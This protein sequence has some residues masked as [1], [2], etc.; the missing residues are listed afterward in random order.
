[1]AV[2]FEELGTEKGY[3]FNPVNLGMRT[4]I[5]IMEQMLKTQLNKTVKDLQDISD[6]TIAKIYIGKTYIFKQEKNNQ[7]KNT[8]QIS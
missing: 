5:E 8:I 1:M 7:G 2:E 6:R 4:K 3:S